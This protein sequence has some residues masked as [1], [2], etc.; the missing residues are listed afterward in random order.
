MFIYKK[1]LIID[2]RKI[3]IE[4]NRFYRVVKISIDDLTYKKSFDSIEN[5]I[6]IIMIFILINFPYEM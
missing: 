3:K 1:S 2:D 6:Y 4:V 5:V